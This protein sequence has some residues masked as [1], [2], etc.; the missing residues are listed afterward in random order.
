M[1]ILAQ[2]QQNSVRWQKQRATRKHMWDHHISTQALGQDMA[3]DS[4]DAHIT[5]RQLRYL[6][7]V[8]RM[9]FEHR[10]PRR[11]LTAWVPNKRPNGAPCMTYGRTIGKAL[12]KFHLDRE[13]W[14]LLRA[15]NRSAWRETLRLVRPS[16][17][18]PIQTARTAPPRA[19]LIAAPAALP[20]NT[21]AD[22]SLAATPSML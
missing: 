6:G 8:S 14:P 22:R 21:H 17:D 3:I 13:T 11:M 15:A 18:P 20:A 2:M 7:H 10:L 12:D 1:R 9:D 4:M 5:R 19:T 16:S